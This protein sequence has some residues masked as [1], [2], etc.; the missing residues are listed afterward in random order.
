MKRLHILLFWLSA[1]GTWPL[2]ALVL[3][4]SQVV[5]EDACQSLNYWKSLTDPQ[6]P[7]R[8]DEGRTR[9]RDIIVADQKFL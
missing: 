4:K 9:L 1:A 6:Q 2:Q 8:Q 3:Q 5:V 7:S